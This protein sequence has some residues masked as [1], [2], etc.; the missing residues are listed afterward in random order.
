MSRQNP[1]V[2]HLCPA[3]KAV[4]QPSAPKSRQERADFHGVLSLMSSE[5]RLRFSLQLLTNVGLTR[6]TQGTETL[7][8]PGKEY[9]WSPYPPRN[10]G[11]S[12]SLFPQIPPRGELIFTEVLTCSHQQSRVTGFLKGKL[13][14]DGKDGERN[15]EPRQSSLIKAQY[16]ILNSEI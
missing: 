9:V 4:P 16:L 12:K 11:C 6:N 7:E 10:L 13:K 15:N 3:A 14:M 2:L 5:V 8:K 1:S